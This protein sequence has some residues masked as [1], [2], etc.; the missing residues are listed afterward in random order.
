MSDPQDD[1]RRLRDAGVP[2]AQT[3]LRRLTDWA[4]P[5]VPTADRDADHPGW[6]VLND[7]IA[8]RIAREPVSKITGIRAFWNHDFAVTPDVLDPRP[9]T[10]T[11]VE[12]AL[13][14]PFSKVLDLGTGSGCIAITLLAERSDVMGVA[15]DL[16]EAALA[17]AARNADAIGVAD[18][19]TLIR[20]DWF[21]DVGGRFDLIVSNPPYI[22]QA[23]M[24]DLAPE[25][26][27]HDPTIALTP[28]R[29]A[30]KPIAKLRP[31]RPTT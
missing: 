1:L 15:T 29:T 10:E 7:A 11:L 18:R 16:S 19:L 14:T 27:D 21:A 3:D 24:A 31:M 26:R 28:V 25:V 6:G 8:R 13:Q 22:S 30:C 4:F 2:D 5:G 9:D 17:V 20:S 23:E 12:V